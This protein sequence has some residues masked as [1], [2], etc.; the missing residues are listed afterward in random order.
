MHIQPKSRLFSSC[1]NLSTYAGIS[2]LETLEE[3]H[4]KSVEWLFSLRV[5]KSKTIIDMFALNLLV[6]FIHLFFYLK[7]YQKDLR[8]QSS[9]L[10]AFRF[11]VA[12]QRRVGS[13]WSNQMGYWFHLIINGPGED[14]D[15]ASSSEDLRGTLDWKWW[16]AAKVSGKPQESSQSTERERSS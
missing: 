8:S 6:P 2:E 9:I 16:E 7:W 4:V 15:A 14:E 11:S 3:T 5:K 1:W 13:V 10:Y 12:G